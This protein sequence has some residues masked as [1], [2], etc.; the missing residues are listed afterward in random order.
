MRK[1]PAVLHFIE[2]ERSKGTKDTEIRHK[3]LDAG[4]HMDIIHH[5][6]HKKD[7]HAHQPESTATNDWRSRMN[8]PLI[9]AGIFLL[10]IL[11][12]LFI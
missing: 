11:L 5:A 2:E 1:K 7:D 10:L 8:Y 4:W 9:G 3:L 6:M 12:A